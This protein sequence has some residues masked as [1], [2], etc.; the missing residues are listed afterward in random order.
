MKMECTEI[1]NIGCKKLIR[2]A[3]TERIKLPAKMW[4]KDLFGLQ[5]FWKRTTH[6]F[7]ALSGSEKLNSTFPIERMLYPNNHEIYNVGIDFSYYINTEWGTEY[8][9]SFLSHINKCFVVML[10]VLRKKWYIF[11]LVKD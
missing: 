7:E 2:N 8:I 6:F 5:L 11:L 10:R 9:W 3:V 4:N 1:F